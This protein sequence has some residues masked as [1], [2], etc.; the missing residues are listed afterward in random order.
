MEYY[1]KKQKR[2]K[3]NNN[4]IFFIAIGYI[5][6]S[7][8]HTKNNGSISKYQQTLTYDIY[9]AYYNDFILFPQYYKNKDYCTISE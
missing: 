4:C 2:N 7:N 3:F 5:I 6:H 1:P 9:N 8:L